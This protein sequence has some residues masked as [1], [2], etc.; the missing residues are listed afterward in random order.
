M[1]NNYKEAQNYQQAQYDHKETQNNY[2][3]ITKDN[4]ET[5]HNQ[6]ETENN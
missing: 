4:K 1:Q 5:Q 2:T 6:K 3:E